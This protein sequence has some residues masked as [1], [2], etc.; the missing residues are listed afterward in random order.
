[1][2]RIA[3]TKYRTKVIRTTDGKIHE[4]TLN[5]ETLKEFLVEVQINK[6]VDSLVGDP[7]LGMEMRN[8]SGLSGMDEVESGGD[9]NVSMVQATPI[10]TYN[11]EVVM[12]EE[13]VAEKGDWEKFL[14]AEAIEVLR[15]FNAS[16]DLPPLLDSPPIDVGQLTTNFDAHLSMDAELAALAEA[17]TRRKQVLQPLLIEMINGKHGHDLV[18]NAERL[19]REEVRRLGVVIPQ[20]WTKMRQRVRLSSMGIVVAKGRLGL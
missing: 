2:R 3:E 15:S 8:D 9:K 4:L 1:M 13:V 10:G 17:I 12:R 18:N 11:G 14:S 7:S 6:C 19:M 16:D 5:P 20:S